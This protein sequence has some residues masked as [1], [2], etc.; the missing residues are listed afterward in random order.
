MITFQAPEAPG[1]HVMKLRYRDELSPEQ[2]DD[3]DDI[4]GSP[5]MML[6]FHFTVVS[7]R[8]HLVAAFG[9]KLAKGLILVS[10]A[11]SDRARI[12]AGWNR[13]PSGRFKVFGSTGSCSSGLTA[14]NRAFSDAGKTAAGKWGFTVPV[15][16]PIDRIRSIHIRSGSQ[17]MCQNVSPLEAVGRPF[18]TERLR[19]LSRTSRP[20]A[21]GLF[22][23]V[24]LKDDAIRVHAAWKSRPAGLHTLV[25]STRPC[26]QGHIG[27]A[28]V[29][30]R[31]RVSRRGETFTA[32]LRRGHQSLQSIRVKVGGKQVACAGTTILEATSS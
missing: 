16:D 21:K 2:P 32:S 18:P 14:V 9:S 3:A 19:S 7:D 28:T 17:R 12:S 23:V 4:V 10:E 5:P 6:T 20:R 11:G 13:R 22:R 1:R 15:M 27:P 24:E 29:W 30:S 31:S 25:G 26:S 8:Q